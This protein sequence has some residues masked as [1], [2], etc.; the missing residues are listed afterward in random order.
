MPHHNCPG[1]HHQQPLQ[2]L[3]EQIQTYLRASM[4]EWRKK[5]PASKS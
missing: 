4:P 2:E 1:P 5:Y 3:A